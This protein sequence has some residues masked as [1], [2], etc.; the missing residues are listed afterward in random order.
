MFAQKVKMFKSLFCFDNPKLSTA[1]FPVSALT[2]S[3][4]T[5]FYNFNYY[6]CIKTRLKDTVWLNGHIYIW[7]GL[8]GK[9]KP[10]APYKLHRN[11][12]CL[13]AKII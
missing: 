5:K 12:F 4:V 7:T 3:T 11:K 6:F 13:M 8:Y 10:F 1:P 2:P 9:L